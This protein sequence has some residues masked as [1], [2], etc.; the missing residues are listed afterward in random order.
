VTTNTISKSKL[1]ER[2]KSYMIDTNK[3]MDIEL[4]MHCTGRNSMVAALP[5]DIVNGEFDCG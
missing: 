1:K 2:L 5:I 3:A 4:F